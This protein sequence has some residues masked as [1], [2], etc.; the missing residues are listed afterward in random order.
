MKTIMIL[1]GMVFLNCPTLIC[2]ALMGGLPSSSPALFAYVIPL[3]YLAFL[4]G[5]AMFSTGV[6]MSWLDDR[7]WRQYGLMTGP[8]KKVPNEF[9]AKSREPLR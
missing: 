3:S 8:R 4:I 1:M 7:S 9:G 5:A 6:V 2:L